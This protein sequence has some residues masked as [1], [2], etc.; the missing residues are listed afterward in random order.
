MHVYIYFNVYMYIYIFMYIY[1]FLGERER[2]YRCGGTVEEAGGGVH[3]VNG[4][5][6]VSRGFGDAE[7]KKTGGPAQD[8]RPVTCNP[9]MGHFECDASDFLLI[10]CDGVSEGAFPNPEVCALAAKVLRETNGDAAA[11]CEAICHMAVETNSKDNISAMIVLMGGPGS[12]QES[13]TPGWAGTIK[14]GKTLVFNPGSVASCDNAGYTSA[15][16]AMCERA[17]V[18]FAGAVEMR[19]KLL[20][21]LKNDEEELILIGTPEG[22]DGSEERR[23][24]FETWAAEREAGGGGDGS[25]GPS[26]DPMAALS[27]MAAGGG[28]GGQAQMMQMLMGMM[29]Q[30]GGGGMGGMEGM[31]GMGGAPEDGR[32][33]RVADLETLQAAVAAHP[34][35]EWDE[36]MA[37]LASTEGIVKTDDPSDGTTHIRFPGGGVVAWLPTGA[38]TNLDGAGGGG[39]SKFEEI[40]E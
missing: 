35:L 18:T 40:V 28:Q 6:A 7:Y 29:Q 26:G 9:E 33:V 1:Y 24:W 34:A 31:G 13:Q 19:Y 21:E 20:M 17:G 22:A 30:G 10:V 25:D 5:L 4:D 8:D 15:Y 32:R 23:R 12:Q 38:L 16:V 36:R 14:M 3:R 37:T 39:G 27:A 2:I 11:A